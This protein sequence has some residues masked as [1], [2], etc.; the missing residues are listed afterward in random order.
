MFNPK[1]ISQRLTKITRIPVMIRQMILA[2]LMAVLIEY[3]RLSPTARA[4]AGLEGL[5]QMSFIRICVM[6]GVGTILLFFLAYFIKAAVWR[7][8]IAGT[9]FL[10][11][12]LALTASFSRT[13]LALCLVILVILI[14]YGFRGWD[15]S[16][17]N[18]HWIPN[19]WKNAVKKRASHRHIWI[20]AGLCGIFLIFA[21]AWTVGR[22]FSFS[23]PTYDF[24]IFSQMFYYMKETGMPLTTVERDGLLSHL[25]VHMSPI[26]YVL[27]PFYWLFPT[28]VT[29]QI[30]QA[31]V[32][33]SA[34]IPL[35]KICA[36]HG[37]TGGK[38]ILICAMLLVYPSF[39][40]G[41]SYDIHENCFL[42]PLILWLFYGIERKNIWI[43]GCAALLT[44]MVKEDAAVYVAVI[45]LW[46]IVRSLIRVP[47]NAMA[48][49]KAT[50]PGPTVPHPTGA[51]SSPKGTVRRPNW[52]LLTG[53]FLLA[54]AFVWFFAATGYLS[55]I[56]D[57]VMTYRYSNFMYDGSSS[58]I[59]VI[60]AVLLNPMKAVFEC[61]DPEK[62]PF[63]ALTLVP[64][65]G[66][67]LM[68]RHYE[69]YIL[70]IPYI[71]VNLMSDYRYQHDI[72][73][74]YAFGSGAC[75]I[76]LCAVN[77][78][79]FK[80]CRLQLFTVI[81]AVLACSLCFGIIIAPKGISYPLRSIKNFQYYQEIRDTLALIPEDA[82]V[83][84]TTFYTT[85]LSQRKILYDVHYSSKKHL[86]DTQYVV[87]T[88]SK[89]SS[90]DAYASP[91]QDNGFDNLVHLLE[92]NGYRLW[93]EIPG[94]LVIYCSPDEQQH[95]LKSDKILQTNV[96]SAPQNH[97][98]AGRTGS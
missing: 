61:G 58:L 24:G 36:C 93:R 67:P 46:L 86:L 37:L 92:E 33:T 90:Y 18:I 64:L 27:L 42:M 88:R 12:I 84:A 14:V 78:S 98:F 55:R 82:S 68:T 32:I 89:E 6:T 7:W 69:R 31:C 34:V 41:T 51:A 25:N 2:W 21:C 54:A 40:G 60:K 75:L 45:A 11:A 62:L 15:S 59:T 38:R 47:E 65:L 66:L 83:T 56:G 72:F 81:A 5:A 30:L 50:I 87:L 97:F 39:S 22:V 23:A 28:P 76:Y 13:F 29:L 3:A 53:I 10:L 77:L 70:L 49:P 85:A 48:S 52:A 17:D 20:M 26:Y 74:Q 96:L 44:L 43:S 19:A 94:V 9:F 73:F 16:P 8:A 63:I 79:D 1:I 35:W 91:G 71:L 4:L 80:K 95:G 57:G